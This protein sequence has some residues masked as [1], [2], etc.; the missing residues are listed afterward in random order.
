MKQLSDVPENDRLD[1]CDMIPGITKKTWDK[2]PITLLAYAGYY[3]R[4][5]MIDHLIQEGASKYGYLNWIIFIAKITI[6]ILY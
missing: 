5:V 3:K 1:V 2:T 4:E 6:F